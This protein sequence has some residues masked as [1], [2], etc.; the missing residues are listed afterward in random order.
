MVALLER[1]KSK[2]GQHVDTS[3]LQAQIFMLDFQAAR[4]LIANEVPKQAGNDH[5]TSIPT[6]VFKTTDGHINIATTGGAIWRRFCQALGAEA[7]M[8]RPE[9]Q[10]AKSRSQNRKALNAEI[11]TYTQHKSSG[12]W[13]DIMN[14]AGVPCGP[15][16]S[17]D[18]VFADP[19]VK[20]LGIARSVKKK[21]G[22]TLNVVGQPVGLSRTK[23]RIAAPPPA[24]GEHTNEVLKE[25]GFS[26]KDIAALRKAR[27]V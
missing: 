7:F 5:P 8:Q 21:D 15:I 14:K 26:A 25:F 24:L 12:E 17:I 20:H 6:G 18:Q 23:S 1:E 11:D 19:Q 4:W 13:I 22:S 10:D 27:A 9:Y 2:K 16:Y 3:L